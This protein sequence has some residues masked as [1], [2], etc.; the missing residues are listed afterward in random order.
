MR[1]QLFLLVLAG[2]LGCGSPGT[3]APP[4]VLYS[5]DATNLLNAPAPGMERAAVP[6]RVEA[7]VIEAAGADLHLLQPGNGWVPWWRSAQYPADEHYR[8]FEHRAGRA[9]DPIGQFMREG[10][11]MV[12]DFI[13]AC[14]AHGVAAGVSL[15]LN[16]YHGSESWDVLRAFARGESRE[17]KVPVGLG[18][19]A[20]QSDV[21]LDRPEN[22]LKPDP[23]AYAALPWAE[24]LAYAAN[25]AT[26]ITLR[27]ARVWNWARPEAPAYKLGFI[28]EL[29]TGYDIDALELDFMRWASF[30][31]LE[32]TG[33]E[34]RRAIMLAFIKE[35]RAALDRGARPGQRRSLG[36]RVPS[37]LSGH[38]PLGIDLAAW[39][40]AGVDWVNLSCHYVSE[41]QTELA[42]VHR[43]IPDTPLYLELTFANSPRRGERRASLDGTE[44]AGGY[45]LMTAEQFYTAAHLAYARGAAGVSLFNFAYY[46]NLG[47]GP[48]EPP[49]SVLTRLKDR[50]WLARQPQ[51]YF[52]SVSGNPPSA[53]SEFSRQRRLVA[54]RASELRLDLA[55]PAGGWRRE[56]GLRIELIGPWGTREMEV[57]LNGRLLIVAEGQ[58]EPFAT[59]F[60]P[61]RAAETMRTWAVPPELLREGTNHIEAK[62][63]AGEPGEMR[64]V[65]LLAP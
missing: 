30:F 1:L 41:Q 16:D 23:A 63:V 3:A 9:S 18:A 20:A 25:P 5:N 60:L 50:E 45:G 24:K 8:R 54:G 32:E 39:V 11:D 42:A 64:M 49:F 62:L 48:H 21:L 51:H 34:Q 19:M 52:L 33:V 40:A 43:L 26:R 56:A 27:T 59:P 53:P 65:E 57:R 58:P 13:R 46:R 38:D 35:T 47:D 10:G 17:A 4:R 22:Q 15:R 37:R 36:V 14:R 2:G 55:A 31:R 28:R 6:A 7:G 61:A 44:E 29:C 12:A